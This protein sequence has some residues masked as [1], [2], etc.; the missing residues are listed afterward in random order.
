MQAM[1][2]VDKIYISGLKQAWRLGVYEIDQKVASPSS[3]IGS[4]ESEP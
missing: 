4:I 3:R 1:L 2:R